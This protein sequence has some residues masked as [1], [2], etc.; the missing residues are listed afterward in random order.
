[1]LIP[2]VLWQGLTQLGPLMELEALGTP[3]FDLPR[4]DMQDG[5]DLRQRRG[6]CFVSLVGVDSCTRSTMLQALFAISLLACRC[7]TRH[8]L[9]GVLCYP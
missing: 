6:L 3:E 5:A 7:A 4:V 9:F 8:A 1:M 2:P